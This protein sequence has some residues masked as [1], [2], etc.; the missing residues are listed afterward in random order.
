LADTEP[1][2]YDTSEP[3]GKPPGP[4]RTEMIYA[5]RQARH[6]ACV[7]PS[8]KAQIRLSAASEMTV[9]R[10]GDGRISEELASLGGR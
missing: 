10:E 5:S 1:D 3:P 8:A 9:D 6:R 2:Q 4:S 7:T